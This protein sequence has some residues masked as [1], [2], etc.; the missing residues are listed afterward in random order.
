MASDR[1]FKLYQKLPVGIQ[2]VMVTGKGYFLR[3]RR[4]GREHDEVFAHLM[5]TMRWDRER[6]QRHQFD[7]LHETLVYAQQH[8]PHY[9]EL[10]GRIGLDPRDIRSFD[11]FAQVPLTSK[12]AVKEDPTRFVSDLYELDD[13]VKGHTSGTTGT[14]LVTYKDKSC[15]QRVWAFQTRQRRFWGITGE[16]P[17]AS[18]RLPPVVPMEQDAPPF[19]RYDASDKHWLFSCFHLA[20]RHLDAYLEKLAEIDAEEINAYP[21][22]VHA[23]A[24]HA[25]RRGFDRIRPTAVLTVAETVLEEQRRVVEEAFGCKIADQYGSAECVGWTSQCPEMTYHVAPEFGYVESVRDGERVRGVEAEVVGTGF[26]NRVQVLIRFQVGDMIV[27]DETP[28]ECPCG[29]QTDTVT[30][31]IGRVDD[32]LYTPDGRAM[33]RLDV[34]FKKTKGVHEAQIIQDARDHLT[35]KL[36]PGGEGFEEGRADTERILQEMFGPDMRIECVRV[37]EIERTKAGKFRSQLNLVG[38]PDAASRQPAGKSET[39]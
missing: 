4:Y 11:D 36:V 37:D 32:V 31:V 21:S 24:S 18:I 16:R 27:F 6:L 35:V 5:E 3:R 23:V 8:V 7:K 2:N 39:V 9:R 33:G 28:R 15:Y 25:L 13:V 26:V 14:P 20:P 1:L 22:A 19:W 12:D 38:P 34:V 17:W 30:R 29:W 10:W